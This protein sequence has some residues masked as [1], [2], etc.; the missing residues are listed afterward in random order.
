MKILIANIPTPKNRFL[1]D[2]SKAFEKEGAS[3]TWDYEKFWACEETFDVVHIH[4]PEYLS[5]TIEAFLSKKDK[6]PNT[7]FEELERVLQYWNNNA[8]VVHT[9]HNIEPHARKDEDFRTLYKLCAIYCHCIV[10]MANYS[11]KLYQQKFPRIKNQTIIPHHNYCS[12]PNTITPEMARKKFGVRPNSSVLLVLGAIRESEKKVISTAYKAIPNSNKYLLAP[13]WKIPKRGWIKHLRLQKWLYQLEC[14]LAKLNPRKKINLGFIAEADLQ[15]YLNAAD[16]LFIPRAN[17]L[18]SGNLPLGFTFGKVVVGSKNGNIGELLIASGNP[19][20][21]PKNKSS[22]RQ[23]ITEAIN[24]LKSV[25]GEENSKKALNEWDV[26]KI[27]RQ[28]QDVFKNA[29]IC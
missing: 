6:I 5:Y 20:F 27:A 24:L 10:H 21:D 12:L 22:V 7:L 8:K 29:A 18:N 3:V 14:L 17:S 1:K 28:Y 15:Y 16:I 11:L 26:D 25:K 2:L 9:V 4:W 23:S 13:G 19:V